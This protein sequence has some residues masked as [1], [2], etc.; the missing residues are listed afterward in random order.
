MPYYQEVQKMK[1][2]WLWMVVLGITALIWYG[3]IIQIV[4]GKPWGTNPMPD[5]MMIV[6]FIIFGIIFPIFFAVTR[7][8]CEVRKDGLYVRF[9]PI[10]LHARRFTW[11]EIRSCKAIEDAGI[12]RFGGW[13]IRINFKGEKAYTAAGNQGIEIVLQSGKVLVIGSRHASKLKKAM[14]LAK[15]DAGE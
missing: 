5:S 8:T 1:Q 3:F 6:F 9:F 4:F 2:W 7:L 11:R 10:H 15:M 12:S 14:D 13:G